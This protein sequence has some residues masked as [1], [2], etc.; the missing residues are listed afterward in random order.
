MIDIHTIGAGGGSIALR[1]RG[2]R[3]PRR[4]AQRRRRSRA[5]RLRPGRRGADAHRRQRRARPARPRPLPRRRDDSSTATLAVAA[6][7]RLAERL[8]IERAG[9]GRGHRH[10]RERQHGA[11]RSARARSQK[12]HDPREF[13]L[14]AFGGA[15]PMQAAEVAES[16]DIPEVIVPPLSRHHLRH[17]P[18]DERPQVRPDAHRLHDRGRDRRGAARPRP[19]G[20]AAELRERLARR[21]RGRRADRRR[22]RARL[23]LRRP[24]LRAAGRRSRTAAS[25][26]EALEHVPP[27]ARAGV[28]PRLPAIRSRSS[29]CASLPT[30]GG[31][32][33]SSC[34]RRQAQATRCSARARASSGGTARLSSHRTRYYDRTLLPSGEAIEGAA[35]VFQRDTT[36]VVPPGWTARAD[37]GG[38][39]ILSRDERTRR[40]PRRPDHRLGDRGRAG[41]DRGRDGPQARPHVLLVDHP[42]VGG[43]RLR[44]LRRAGAAAGRVVAVHAASVRPDPRLH[45][46][47]Q[48]SLRRARRGVEARRRGH[49]QPRLLRRLARAG[50]RLRRP[51]LPRR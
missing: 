51:D 46:R 23:P 24:G 26:A 27:P 43:L 38:S 17:G 7:E 45:P 4:A 1:R 47:H 25:H 42:R 9:G 6:V 44:D 50:R 34:R 3:V 15:G 20:A 16:L 36:T 22:L 33:S 35:I 12:G 30:G 41:V 8:G 10:D 5:R 28:R 37:A 31:R 19:R 18:A 2:R 39:L 14:V 48:P 49:P 11:A 32:R 13:A 29:T 21:R 40:H